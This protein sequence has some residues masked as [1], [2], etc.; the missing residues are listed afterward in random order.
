MR[1]KRARVSL[2]NLSRGRMYIYSSRILTFKDN[3]KKKSVKMMAR[4][5]PSRF[6]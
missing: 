4:S 6:T 1:L 2:D 3:K 5:L